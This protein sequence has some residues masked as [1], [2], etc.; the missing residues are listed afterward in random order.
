MMMSSSA[1]LSHITTS[2][3]AL[4]SSTKSF[5][6]KNSFES[7]PDKLKQYPALAD[8]LSKAQK[9]ILN[10]LAMKDFTKS[11]KQRTK[12][13]K[14][15]NAIKRPQT[16]FFLYLTALKPE[17]K[18]DNPDMRMGSVAKLATERWNVASEEEKQVKHISTLA[19][20]QLPN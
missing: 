19:F 8:L 11:E 14:H 7:K 12:K 20:R 16:A 6:E 17:I 15:P 3:L 13:P 2:L 18:K 5:L 1:A 9:D 10:P 4:Q